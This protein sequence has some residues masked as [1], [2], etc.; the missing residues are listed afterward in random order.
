MAV[1]LLMRKV[2][3][4][5]Y[6]DNHQQPFESTK[7]VPYQHS[8]TNKK[9]LRSKFCLS[10]K[11]AVHN[12]ISA[13]HIF[14][15]SHTFYSKTITVIHQIPLK[16]C[17]SIIIYLILLIYLLGGGGGGLCTE[18]KSIYVPVQIKISIPLIHKKNIQ[19]NKYPLVQINK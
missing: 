9:L 11:S 2:L 6:Q 10:T 8:R 5:L 16:K 7:K 15:F 4:Q 13:F 1:K 17:F 14:K 19:I 12:A 3:V 18:D